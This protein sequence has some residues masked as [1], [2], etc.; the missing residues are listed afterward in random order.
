[1]IAWGAGLSLG[2][3]GPSPSGSWKCRLLG[4]T[5]ERRGGE[6]GSASGLYRAPPAGLLRLGRWTE[7]SLWSQKESL[8]Q[9]PVRGAPGQSR[10]LPGGDAPV[11]HFRPGAL[12]FPGQSLL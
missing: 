11:P 9:G 4:A 10:P 6:F 12:L 1:M 5:P 7:G 3:G 2:G 8:G